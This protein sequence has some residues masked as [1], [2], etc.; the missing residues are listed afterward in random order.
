MA[1]GLLLLVAFTCLLIFGIKAS[2]TK[3]EP[4]DF[5]LLIVAGLVLTPILIPLAMATIYGKRLFASPSKKNIKGA[6]GGLSAIGSFFVIALAQKEFLPDLEG[7]Y[8]I[9]LISIVAV[10]TY[11][12]ISKF[13][14]DR[15]L[16]EPAIPGEFIGPGI[17]GILAFLLW[18]ALSTFAQKNLEPD[19]ITVAFIPIIV[20]YVF[21]YIALRMRPQPPA[22]S[23][24]SPSTPR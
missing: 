12:S 19:L 24:E 8:T 5:F 10:P 6:V 21:F 13:L 3:A 22:S 23:P 2:L 20:A 7:A 15:F 11:S 14:I 9:L 4:D 18:G 16:D 17:I 1:V